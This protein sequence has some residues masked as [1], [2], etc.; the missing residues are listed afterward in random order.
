MADHRRSLHP[1]VEAEITRLL[2]QAN[3]RLR[4]TEDNPQRQAAAV[5]MR[6]CLLAGHQPMLARTAAAG[7]LAAE[8]HIPEARKLLAEATRH[9]RLRVREPADRPRLLVVH[10]ARFQDHLRDICHIESPRRLQAAERVLAHPTLADRWQSVPPRPATMEELAWVHTADHIRR[11]ALT[12]GNPLTALD[13][14]TQTTAHSF[15]TACLAVGGV[16]ELIDA[17]WQGRGPCGFAF[18]RPPGHHAEPNRAMGFCL[19]NNVAL[20]ACYLHRIYGVRRVMIVDIDAHH[21][22]GTQAAFYDTDQVLFASLHEFPAYPGTGR[23]AETGA[24]RGQGHTVNLPMAR[25]SGD[26]EIAQ[27]LHWIVRPL[28]RAYRPEMILVS[29]GFDLYQ[30]DLLSGMQATADGYA[31]FGHM[32]AETAAE[33]CEGRIV[34]VLEGGYHVESI[35]TCGLRLIQT[36]C[37]LN[38]DAVR[39]LAP[40]AAAAPGGALRKAIAIHQVQWP[41]LAGA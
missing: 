7:L 9:G 40:L 5:F 19:F 2:K 36:L 30:R 21:G 6:T 10:D 20:G 3:R 1:R 23:L 41:A 15:D 11:I 4:R 32:L 34:F 14:D 24:G 26:R 31:L 33:V 25:A 12:A 38:G 39:R 37:G 17:V 35:E 13:L 28:A 16:L 22:N 8:A 27:A 18:V 29:C